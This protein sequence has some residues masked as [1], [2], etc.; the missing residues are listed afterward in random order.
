MRG[1]NEWRP[2]WYGRM[3]RPNVSIPSRYTEDWFVYGVDVGNLAAAASTTVTFQI[4]ADAD[5]EWMK[6]EVYANLNGASE[7]ISDSSLLPVTI[8]IQDTGSGDYLMNIPVPIGTIFGQGKL[9]HILT[10]PRV[11]S[12]MSVISLTF[13]NFDG[14]NQYNNIYVVFE[15]RK[16]RDL[17]PD[18][19]NSLPKWL[20][21]AMR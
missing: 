4:Q 15:G 13:N 20:K 8:N 14:S 6:A 1:D 2:E 10:V 3:S 19:R 18:W 7:P 17:G 16:V 21:Q 9:P 11:F 12:R 5:F